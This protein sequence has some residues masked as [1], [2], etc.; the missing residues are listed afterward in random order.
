MLTKT[1]AKFFNTALFIIFIMSVNLQTQAQGL[2]PPAAKKFPKNDT[3]PG[4]VRIDNYYW[5][6]DRN[7]PD[8]ISYL[9][10]ENQYTQAMMKHTEKLQKD[11]YKELLGRIKETDLTVP[12]KI[13]DYYYYTRTEQGK[14]YSIYCRKKVSLEAP[15]EITLNP[16]ELAQGHKYFRLGVYEISPDH[17]L[18]AYSI[19]TTGSES[20]GLFIKDL[21][22][23]KLFPEQ[24][25]NTSYSVQW[26]NDNQT[27]FYNTLDEAKR[28]FKLFRHKLGT[29]P[30]EDVLVYHEPDEAYYLDVSKTKSRKY[31]ILSLVSNTT[32]E[33]HHLDADNP[34]Q[35]FKIIHPRQKE[36]EYHLAH[37]GD[38]FYI[39]TNDNA[40]N[41]K[42]MGAP[43]S[44]PAKSNWKEIIPPSDSIKL[45]NLETFRDHLVIYERQRGLKKIRIINLNDNQS[46]YVDFPEPVYTFFSSGNPDFNTKLLRFNYMSLVTPNSV[47]DYDMEAKTRELKKQEEVLGSYDPSQYQSERIFA[48]ADDGTQIPISLVYKKGMKRD[49]NNP[50]Y[51]YG[52]GSYGASM[53]PFFNSNRLTLL[54]RGFIYA[55]AH[56]RG[57]GEMGR[58]WYDQGKL[59]NKKNT[60]TDFIACAQ[61]LIK[62]KYTS[63]EELVIS[64][65]SAGGL[66]MGAVANMRPDLFKVVVAKVP[67]VDVVN[68]M[69]DASIP[70]TVTEYEEWGNPNEKRYLDYMKSY[71]PYDNVTAQDYPNLLITAGL[72]DPRVAYWEPSKW[73]AKLRALKTDHNI[74]LLKV[75]LGAGHGGPSGRYEQLK[76]TAFEFAFIFEILGIKN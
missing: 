72:N 53:D 48:T 76:E 61:H 41:F 3:L 24:I 57:G 70:L 10:A 6:R 68:T 71:S 32:T 11:L 62:E 27:I 40:R 65:G 54:D 36:M 15:E 23:G 20:Y 7:N 31:L 51:L 56:I 18:L 16:N 64:G 52:Y 22:T 74:L 29:R 73:A 63:S 4:E 25:E 12:V 21:A 9:E 26:A 30:D 45:D 42:L 5:L 35:Q 34:L 8:V 28:P 58:Y 38:K 60:F 46:Q 1:L 2:T 47:F 39:L 13:D 43:V 66:L 75:N 69:L 49:G 14:Q 17:K 59:L 55:I 50:L 33:V 19:D 44:D 67:F 37:H